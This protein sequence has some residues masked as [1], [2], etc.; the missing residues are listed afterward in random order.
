MKSPR[1]FA[2]SA[3]SAAALLLLASSVAVPLDSWAA[4]FASGNFVAYRVGAETGARSVY[5]DE[6]SADGTLVQSVA[7]SSTAVASLAASTTG[8]EGL[9]N[10]SADGKCL[11]VPGYA[12]QAGATT[13]KASTTTVAQRAVAV[14]GSNAVAPSALSLMGATAFNTDSIRSAISSD[15]AAIWVS[16]NGDKNGKGVWFTTQSGA[17]PKI[18]NATN[19]QGLSIQNSQLFVSLAGGGTL[20]QLGS[21]LPQTGTPTA[22]PVAALPAN[23]FR[24]IAF[25]KLNSQ[26]SSADTLYVA[27]NDANALQKYRWSGSQ[28]IA[29][30]TATLSGVHGLVAMP[31]GEGNVMLLATDSSGQLF[32][33]FD[34]SGAQGSLSGTPALVTKPATAGEAFYG[35]ALAPESAPPANV[36]SAP[37]AVKLA[38]QNGN[39]GT[40][41]WTAPASGAA[42]AFYV[43]ESSRDDFTTIDQSAV[44]TKT[45]AAL[46]NLQS[47]SQK[48]RVRAVNSLGGSASAASGNFV[49]G[50]PPATTLLDN[51]AYSG[52]VGDAND[53]LA[54]QGIRFGV[55]DPKG[56]AAS[57]SVTATSSA[58]NVISN[59]TASNDSGTITLKLTPQGVGYADITLTITGSSGAGITRTIRYA[60]S[61]S[62]AA[63]AGTRWFAGRSDASSALITSSGD[64]LV[65][66]DEAPAKDASG[67]ALAG[68]NA[69]FGYSAQNG[70][71]PV[72]QLVPDAS[73]G[74]SNAASCSNSGFTGLANC[75][76][77]GEVDL[78]SSILV[79]DRMYFAG[80]HSNNKNGRSRPDRWRFF[81]VD[82]AS[83]SVTGYYQWLREDLRTW[84]AGNAHGLGANYLGLVSSSDGGD[85]NPLKAPET[86]TLS[87]FSIEGSTTSP[88]DGQ[89][90]LG[91]RAPLVSAPGQPAVTSDV[92]TNRTHALIIPVGNYAGMLGASGGT[93]GS[94]QIAAPIRL[95]LGG[96]GIREIRKNANGDYL[97]I[98]GPPNGAN[99]T[100]PRDF[101]LFSWDGRVS[102]N[103]LALN[104]RVLA[105]DV[106]A[107]TP[108]KTA[109]SAEGIATLPAQLAQ[110]GAATIIS[111]CG[112][113]DF[114]GDGSAAKDLAFAAWKK[115]R[116]DSVSIAAL[117]SVTWTHTASATSSAD[118]SAQSAQAGTLYAIVLAANAPA[119]S[120]EQVK[121]GRD[122]T[123][124]AALW[125]SPGTAL[126]ANQP[127]KLQASGLATDSA[128][129]A[130]SV[131]VAADGSASLVAK[132]EFRTGAVVV[133][134]PTIQFAEQPN[135]TLGSAPITVSATGNASNN[136]VQFA[137]RTEAVCKTGGAQGATVTLLTKGVCTLRATQDG[138]NGS[139]DATPVERSFQIE[140]P[141][142]TGNTLPGGD[143]SSGSVS[144]NGWQFAG[145]S[146]GSAPSASLP[147]LPTGYR[148]VLPSGFSFVLAGGTANGPANVTW[149]WPQAAPSGAMLWKF[150]PTQANPTPHWYDVKGQ[151]NGARTSGSF[152][153]TDGGDGDEDQRANGVI[154]DPVFLVAPSAVVE[155]THTTAVPT[156]SDIGKA[157]LALAL[158]GAAALNM[159]RRRS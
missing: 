117:P 115:F 135:R 76:A 114:Y 93:K 120:W 9:L 122:S 14:V 90:W 36:P 42:V 52:V 138:A 61:A 32:R 139:P 153:I 158:A 154:V 30:G 16:G 28:W 5:L 4:P 126:T 91:F 55:S 131:I 109:C 152:A 13:L 108:P 112:D 34:T 41:Q 1:P 129:V 104:V 72:S 105:A 21:N 17:T 45:S 10:R 159:R 26:S 83:G 89:L 31:T 151:L 24:G 68:G 132:T 119:P 49:I 156:L 123:D 53:A 43:I 130:Y 92:A 39:G 155:P 51:T 141:A 79:G 33:L 66:D 101:R 127:A 99:G 136:P 29:S 143:G 116:S 103:G 74:L 73:L 124:Q 25:V 69:V 98:A 48:V 94:A 54:T 56:S 146:A 63:T 47:G 58:P 7:L 20:N 125:S 111:D 149:Q 96:R 40:I 133:V 85:K 107:F 38:S 71:L 157:L 81:G 80:S 65:V 37:T 110:G 12:A 137:S 100:A 84:D 62:T 134:T 121:A 44:S 70:G 19:A 57:V 118:F 8:S 67:N 75:S 113:A 97:I 142:T 106:A 147:P 27:A 102:S 144:G 148:F 150:G 35:L 23:N 64:M 2:P 46:S 18:L 87:G 145:N 3:T 15:C 82:A 59:I 6:Y 140:L 78:E 11:T 95:D 86:D 60:A 50:E 88:D 77:D 22:T 128:Y